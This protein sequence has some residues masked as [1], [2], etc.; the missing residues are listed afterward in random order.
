MPG[1]RREEVAQLAAISVDHY[2]RLEQGRIS[3]S[4]SVLMALA[5]VL[6][7]DDDQRSY[8]SELAG[9]D[10]A[11]PRRRTRQMVRPSLRRLLDDLNCTPAFVLGRRMDILAWNPLAASL[12]T[13]FAQ[14]PEKDRNY[15]RIV[16]TDPAMRSLYAE[17]ESV[18]RTCVALLRREA[19]SYPNDPQL[20]TLV[21]ELSVQDRDFGQ[22]W[23]AHHVGGQ[24]IG[25]KNLEHPMVGNLC[26]DWDTLTCAS[27]P[28]QQLVTWSADPGT[29]DHDRLS[30]LA[31]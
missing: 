6:L 3:A 2:T 27:D 21:G 10:A 15:I 14:I 20:I 23:A 22:W 28:D 18:A 16:F 7:L 26:L 31:S 30:I 25:K 12:V 5:R 19:A 9:K 29:P 11:Q 1:L 24:R 17:W 8:L 13:D 4:A